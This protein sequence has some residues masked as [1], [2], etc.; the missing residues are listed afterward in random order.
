VSLTGAL[1]YTREVFLTDQPVAN[2]AEGVISLRTELFSYDDP[3]LDFTT[4][5]TVLPS[6]TKSGR[7]RV[8]FDTKLRYEIFKDF[9]WSIS[10]WDNYDSKPPDEASEKND[11]GLTTS[12]GWSF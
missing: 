7:V 8:D 1:V 11:Y 5:F 12:V 10:F 4:T 6:M 9:F 2:S 3:E